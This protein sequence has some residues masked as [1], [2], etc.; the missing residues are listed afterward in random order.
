MTIVGGLDVHRQQITFDYLDNDG[1]VHWGQT[2]PATRKTLR[3]WLAEHCPDGDGEFVLEGCTGWRYVSE[4]LAAVGLGV[5]LGDLAEIAALRGPRKRAKTDLADARLVRTLQLAGGFPKSWVP[6]AHVVEIRTL[7]R[8]YCALMEERRGWQ[9]RIHAHLL[10]QG[11]PPV[12]AL[13]S[14]AGREALAG[15]Q[16]SAAGRQCVDTALRRIEELTIE[17]DPLRMQLESFARRQPRCRAL[18]AHYGI[19]WLYAA[20]MW[21]GDGDARR[22]SSS[23]QLVRFA[24]LDVTVYSSDRKREPGHLSRQGSPELRWTAVEAAKCAVR[25]SSPDYADYHT[26]AA[27][28]DG[29]NRMNPTLAVEH[30]SCAAVITRRVT[31]SPRQYRRNPT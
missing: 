17:I 2:R 27:K 6:P 5:H 26:L 1:L 18:Q 9:Q 29:H 31:H 13:L 20:I 30:R 25:R 22:F 8:L 28:H 16:L 10:H 19:G 14:E 24:R 4:E 11:C 12:K 15:A 3:G 21:A 23:D 7:G